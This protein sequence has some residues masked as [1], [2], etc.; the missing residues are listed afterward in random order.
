[1]VDSVVIVGGG[2]F[3]ATAAL[4]LA[5][6]GCRVT[7]LEAGALPRPAAAS[8]DISKIVRLEYG[9]DAFYTEAAERARQ[10]WLDWNDAWRQEGRPAL[11]HETGLLLLRRQPA[12]PGEFEHDSRTLLAERGHA[13]ETVGPTE[14]ARRWPTW[15]EAGFAE[16]IFDPGGGYVESAAVVWALAEDAQQAGVRILPQTAAKRLVVEEGRVTGVEDA[17]G[18]RHRADRVV[19]AAGS[20]TAELEPRLARSL[21]RTYQPVWH[22][23]PRHPERFRADRFPV[24]LA[25]ITRTGYYGF[26]L[27]PVHAVVKI[28]RH[29]E[30]L[31]GGADGSLTVP[32]EAT[33]ALREF[34]AETVPDLADAEVVQDRLCPYCDTPDEHFWIAGDPELPGLVVASGGSGHAFKFAPLLGGW[35]ADAVEGGAA[36]ERFRWRPELTSADG[37]EPT[38]CRRH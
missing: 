29:A 15:A 34:L 18:E 17:S 11:Y 26:P 6:R 12:A 4:E 5:R 28:G 19:L 8:T 32:P 16:G 14:L 24:F 23:R 31:E 22:L 35:I 30:G 3:G 38:R 9:V 33:A 36:E 13:V 37:A 27:H 7:L 25:D 1:M 10:G 2:I 20:W 21:R